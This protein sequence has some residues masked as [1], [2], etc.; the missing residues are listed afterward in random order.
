MKNI[1]RR[2]KTKVL[3]SNPAETRYLFLYNSSVAKWQ[4]V[5]AQPEL[6]EV[7]RWNLEYDVLW[8]EHYDRI[9]RNSHGNGQEQF[10]HSMV[11]AN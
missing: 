2:V 8:K 7:E 10:L 1:S 9:T 11:H 5:N 6:R 3:N 4:I